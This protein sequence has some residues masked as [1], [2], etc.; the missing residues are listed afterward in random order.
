MSAAVDFLL[1][2]PQHLIPQHQLSRMVYHATR[3]TYAP[4]KNT[5]IKTFIRKYR[6]DMDIAEHS[7]AESYPSFN[8]FF[9]RAL[10]EGARPVENE[11]NTICS[12]VD[13]RI[14]QIGTIH[15]DQLIQAKGKYFTLQALLGRLELAQQFTD[16]RFATLYL[17]PRDYHRIHM[18]CEGRLR[19]ILYIPGR[20]FSVSPRTTRTVDSLFARNERVC[21]LFESAHGPFAL[22]LVGAIF[23]GSMSTVW[24]GDITPAHPR[25]LRQWFFDASASN[26]TM[27]CGE[28]LGR[29]NMGSTVIVVFPK[30]TVHWSDSLLA[31]A[32]LEMGVAIGSYAH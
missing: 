31:D 26:T 18:P 3:S 12:P 32:F 8:A 14:S 23:V 17:S 25:E 24:T 28:E 9:T 7:N 19:Q 10:N 2:L 4:W 21:L 15:D 22:V 5:L 30:N 11:T 27:Q 1:T 13:A 29:F 20:L 6:V 16:G